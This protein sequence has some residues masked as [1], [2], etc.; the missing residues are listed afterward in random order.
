MVAFLVSTCPFFLL[1]S[2][3]INED[4]NTPIP[5]GRDMPNIRNVLHDAGAPRGLLWLRMGRHF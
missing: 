3:L 4:V 2:A 1:F 5:I